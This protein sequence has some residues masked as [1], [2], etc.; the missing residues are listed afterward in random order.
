M[1]VKITSQE[2]KYVRG[3]CRG[4]TPLASTKKKAGV[5]QKMLLGDKENVLLM[6]RSVFHTVSSLVT[7]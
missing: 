2:N 1:A 6:E 5:S 3:I 7:G 4:L